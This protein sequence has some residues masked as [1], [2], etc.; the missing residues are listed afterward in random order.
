MIKNLKLY[1]KEKLK[2][3]NPLAEKDD[4]GNFIYMDIVPLTYTL[5]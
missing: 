4:K 2:E 5:P 1:R 3:A